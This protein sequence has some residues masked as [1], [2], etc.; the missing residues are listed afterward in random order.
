MDVLPEWL[1]TIIGFGGLALLGW[2][3]LTDNQWKWQYAFEYCLWWNVADAM[4]D[5]HRAAYDANFGWLFGETFWLTVGL[6]GISIL[7]RHRWRYK[8]V[9]AE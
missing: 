8:T 7:R 5:I 9:T 4:V 1:N 2:G 3:Y 6:S